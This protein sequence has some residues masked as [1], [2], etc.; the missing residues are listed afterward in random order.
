MKPVEALCI[1]YGKRLARPLGGLLAALAVLEAVLIGTQS[2]RMRN[3]YLPYEGLL[4]VCRIDLIYTAVLLLGLVCI[5]AVIRLDYSGRSR[6]VYTLMTLPQPR[7]ALPLSW[8]AVTLTFLVLLAALQLALACALYPLYRAGM[9][10]AAEQLARFYEVNRETFAAAALPPAGYT[11]GLYRA[12]LRYHL[13]ECLLPRTW[14]T[15]LL[16]AVRLALPTALVS[17]LG[18]RRRLNDESIVLVLAVGGALWLTCLWQF[19]PTL[20]WW[21]W[22]IVCALLLAAAGRILRNAVRRV[23]Q[24]GNLP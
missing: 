6:G 12:L 13:F 17:W 21:E 3:A 22:L 8:A 16:L 1:Y 7:R 15:A 2:C 19:E 5:L 18:A 11:R 4:T 14:L 10:H 20:K 23:E 24:A 9:A